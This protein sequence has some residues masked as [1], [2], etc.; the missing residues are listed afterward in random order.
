MGDCYLDIIAPTELI[1]LF[2]GYCSYFILVP[3]TVA[4]IP[5]FSS[6]SGRPDGQWGMPPLSAYTPFESL[7]FFQSLASLESRP[8]SFISISDLLRNNPYVRQNVAFDADR[9]APEALEDLYTTL[10]QDGFEATALSVSPAGQ[11]GRSAP[12]SPATANPKKRKISSPRP[13][14]LVEGVAHHSRM[15]PGLVA[16]LY[17]KYKELVTRDIRLEEKLYGEIRD[18]IERL[19]KEESEAHPPTAP[20]QQAPRQTQAPHGIASQQASKPEPMDVDVKEQGKTVQ[21]PSAQFNK[22]PVE[23]GQPIPQN[24]QLNA[25]QQTSSPA[26]PFS[27]QQPHI[28]QEPASRQ[29]QPNPYVHT[30]H[31]PPPPP[32][33]PQH[34]NGKPPVAPKPLNEPPV[35]RVPPSAVP[36]AGASPRRPPTAQDSPAC[37]GSS[38]PGA[39]HAPPLEPAPPA[40]RATQTGPSVAPAKVPQNYP[41]H[42]SSFQQWP[43]NPASAPPTP[44][45][46]LSYGNAPHSAKVTKKPLPSPLPQQVSQTETGKP[47]PQPYSPAFPATPGPR[48]H[49][50][51]PA[52][53]PVGGGYETPVGSAQPASLSELRGFRPH[54]PSIDTSGSATPWKRALRLSI[55][56]SPASPDRP[57]PEDVSPISDRDPS[58]FESTGRTCEAAPQRRKGT[59]ASRDQKVPI[60][61]GDGKSGPTRADRST[62]RKR[63]ESTPSSRSRGRSIP[64]HDAFSPAD[65]TSAWQGNIKHEMPSTPA[66]VLDVEPEPRS[67]AGRRGTGVSTQE[68]RPGRGRPKRKRGPS[69]VIEPDSAQTE[70]DRLD[71]SQ[72]SQFV[73]SARNFPRTGAPIMND[74]T[75]HKHASIFTKPLTERD[76]PGYRDL[77]YRPQDLK[78]IK[79][80]IHQGSKAV[81]AAT[82][83][84][85]TPVADGESPAPTG[86]PSKNAVL[87]LPK[88]EDVIPPKAVV[89]SAQ[90]EKELIRMF[91]NAIMFNPVPERGFGPAFPMTSDNGSRESTQV[92][93]ADEGGIINDSLEMFADVE[94]AVTRWRRAE[95][96]ADE[97]AT[98]SILSLRRGS[99]VNNT[100]SADDARGS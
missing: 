64:S 94:Q 25:P 68:E 14:G 27:P 61:D 93:D 19:Q 86:T 85:N 72:S 38:V 6:P 78:S 80:L 13:E 26:H 83:A 96:T 89:N 98:K 2:P 15:V 39:P 34:V 88:T 23:S 95:R 36:E 92:P 99:D 73:L 67:T 22:H 71:T 35:P 55:P 97:L 84:A 30:G 29:P 66:G 87:M 10:M 79:S 42:Q 62:R 3:L 63:D 65:S 43:L 37:N 4:P 74:V 82:E 58:P 47:Y 40:Q 59:K 24:K 48:P 41:Q 49:V 57:R 90:L 53:I 81:A 56:Q 7:L 20:T 33:P 21:Q 51:S 28:P 9:L 8:S 69:E 31:A 60:S 76:A 100:D 18:D 54:R 5:K 11:N 75:M 17:A 44:Q 45:H 12:D 52:P 16:H 77:I 70:I 1:L 46:P 50:Q 91:A 32:P